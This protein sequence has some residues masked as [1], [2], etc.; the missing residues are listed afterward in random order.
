[1]RIQD[2]LHQNHPRRG[3]RFFLHGWRLCWQAIFFNFERRIYETG[4]DTKG[5]NNEKDFGNRRV[6]T[7]RKQ[8]M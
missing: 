8:S 5:Q 3:I 7:G 4:I 2:L 1:M 6:W